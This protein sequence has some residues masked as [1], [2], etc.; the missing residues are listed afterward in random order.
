MNYFNKNRLVFWIMILVILINISAFTTFYIFYKTD[1]AAAAADTVCCSGT[2]RVL[3]EKLGLNSEQA[4]RVSA[5]NRQFREKT[6]PIVGDIK[7][8]R[9]AMLDELSLEKPDTAKL[10]AYTEKIGELQ[11][12]LQKA[13]I[14][15]FRQLKQ[16]CT[17]EQCRKLSSIYSEVYGCSKMGREGGGCIQNQAPQGQENKACDKNP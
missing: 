2:C 17:A 3:N 12:I 11:K 8:T 10:T 4:A 9:V 5:I 13:A 14:D 6:E 7:E 15:Q 16:V 1:K